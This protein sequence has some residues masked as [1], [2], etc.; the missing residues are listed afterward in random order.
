MKLLTTI[1]LVVLLG[2]C[3]RIPESYAVPPQ[4]PAVEGEDPPTF[5]GYVHMIDKLVTDYLVS[6]VNDGGPADSWRWTNQ[7]PTFRF[8]LTK[9]K[10][11]RFEANYTISS[12]TL[13]TTGPVTITWSVNGHALGKVSESKEGYRNFSKPVPAEWLILNGENI[14]VGEV[15]KVWVS[16]DD[17]AK[18]GFIISDLGFID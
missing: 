3:S 7:K 1:L 8:K 4:H 17:G 16:P 18:L 2:A 5:G 6:G 10:G 9:V 15:D 13:S 14:V 11:M 12:A